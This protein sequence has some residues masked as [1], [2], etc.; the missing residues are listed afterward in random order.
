[1]KNIFVALVIAVI[2]IACSKNN[3]TPIDP[4][5]AQIIA[6]WQVDSIFHFNRGIPVDTVIG[7]INDYYNFTINKTLYSK[8]GDAT[9]PAK[10]AQNGKCILLDYQAYE[11][12][13]LS[14]NQ[15][16]IYLSKFPFGETY[17]KLKK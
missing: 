17:I 3:N 1:M 16:H 8:V 9:D 14:S 7:T 5:D 12:L 4:I 15:F 6:K 13:K 2:L 10:W 11:I